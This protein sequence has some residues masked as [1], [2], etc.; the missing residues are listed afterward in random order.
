MVSA[1]PV[2]V[3]DGDPAIRDGVETL[4]TT[5]DATVH[6]FSSAAEFFDSK[7]AKNANVVVCA[8]QLPD[9]NGL[10]VF[11]RLKAEGFEGAFALLLSRAN[12]HLACDARRI[13]VTN[14]FRKP[15]ITMELMR[16]LRA[17]TRA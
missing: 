13:G 11:R 14:V 4:V 5:T 9:A 17:S 8:D 1:A 16:F 6:S 2:C 10:D 3:I 12:T 15:L 7:D